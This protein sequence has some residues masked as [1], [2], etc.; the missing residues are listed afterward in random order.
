MCSNSFKS[1]DPQTASGLLKREM[2]QLDS[3]ILAAADQTRVPAGSALAVDRDMFARKVGAML[4]AC[5]L[6]TSRCV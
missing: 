6:Y 4:K 1:D 3:I 2:R 5:L